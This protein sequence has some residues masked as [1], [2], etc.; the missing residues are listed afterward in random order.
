MATK[1]ETAKLSLD[2][3]E[4]L[5]GVRDALR[6]N[7]QLQESLGKTGD[8]ADKAEKDLGKVGK[9]AGGAGLGVAALAGGVAGLAAELAGSLA[10][11]IKAAVG[12]MGEL[13]GANS[14]VAHKMQELR[15][16]GDAVLKALIPAFNRVLDVT[17]NV[18]DGVKALVSRFET[19]GTSGAREALEGLGVKLDEL[20]PLFDSVKRYVTQLYGVLS[21]LALIVGSVYLEIEKL[22]LKALGPLLT[23]L[24]QVAKF[25]F[26][27]LGDALGSVREKTQ[28][29]IQGNETLRENQETLNKVTAA[30]TGLVADLGRKRTSTAKSTEQLKE[31]QDKYVASLFAALDAEIAQGEEL[32]RVGQLMRESLKPTDE[33]A[34]GFRRLSDE[35]SGLLPPL[36]GLDGEM[37]QVDD[38]GAKTAQRLSTLKDVVKRVAQEVRDLAVAATELGLQ[39]G[40]GALAAGVSVLDLDLAGLLD[41]FAE[42]I[43]AALGRLED[44]GK[45]VGGY[46]QEALGELPGWVAKAGAAAGAALNFVGKTAGAAIGFVAG[47]VRAVDGLLSRFAGVGLSGLIFGDPGDV[48]GVFAE[49]GA[50]LRRFIKGIP[51]LLQE[52]FESGA[53]L[54]FFGQALDDLVGALPRALLAVVDFLTAAA[55]KLVKSLPAILSALIKSDLGG[56]V[57][58]VL[59]TLADQL[60][61]LI[62]QLIALG[63]QILTGVVEALPE[64]VAALIKALPQIVVGLARALFD[65]LEGLLR[66]LLRALGLDKLADK[67]GGDASFNDTPGVVRARPGFQRF[68]FA[69]GDH[70]VAAKN[71]GDLAK[72]VNVT[73]N[74]DD[75]LAEL[76]RGRRVQEGLASLL[77]T[78]VGD[79]TYPRRLNLEPV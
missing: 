73:L 10:E 30:A 6:G 61:V 13:G 63:G 45:R 78:M 23:K 74:Q 75:V 21:D 28:A 69:P 56:L 3:R 41:M 37:G 18:V 49:A 55:S 32:A 50:G 72:M 77:A 26:D 38:S 51:D 31:A 70:V 39:L 17:L 20:T 27:L 16:V 40:S 35:A 1:T 64:L 44:F 15:N 29:F 48:A 11:N 8:A 14:Q 65:V 76:R 60:P 53:L 54:E 79:Q 71:P 7:D 67:V 12:R 52:V 24:A 47:A 62:P 36:E 9:G 2:P 4:F 25:G 59:L 66:G 33:L 34:K 5:K 42:G 22:V 57:R 68:N 46:L 43:P 58:D 19:V